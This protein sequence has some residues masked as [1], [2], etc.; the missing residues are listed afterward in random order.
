MKKATSPAP[1]VKPKWT[2]ADAALL[3]GAIAAKSHKFGYTPTLGGSVIC[4][5]LSNKNINIFF[6]PNEVTRELPVDLLMWLA[7]KFG[8][9]KTIVGGPAIGGAPNGVVYRAGNQ[10][11]ESKF[12]HRMTFTLD[13][14]KIEVYVL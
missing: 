12:K 2:I 9:G 14:R 11:V 10:P 1:V 13:G 6:V 3:I 4:K 8:A 7:E 5:G